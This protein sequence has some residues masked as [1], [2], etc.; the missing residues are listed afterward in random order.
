MSATVV[1]R[2]IGIKVIGLTGSSGGE[3]AKVS[4][5]CIRVPETETYMIQ[6]LHLPVYHCL[7]LMLE[8]RFFSSAE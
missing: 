3:L 7:C 2:A 6:E 8:D 4:D 1:A 5:V